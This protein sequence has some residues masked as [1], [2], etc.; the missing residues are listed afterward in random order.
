MANSLISPIPIRAVAYV[1]RG[2]WVAECP[3]DECANV[4]FIDPRQ[5]PR[6]K[7]TRQMF[8]CTYCNMVAGILW[9]PNADEI[10]VPLDRRPIPKTRNWYPQNH[11]DAIRYNIEHGQSVE[12]LWEENR[13][14]GVI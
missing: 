4:E 6:T 1:L 13:E 12:D 5:N 11:P 9:P 14:H 7:S 8:Y 2:S 10:M 3:R